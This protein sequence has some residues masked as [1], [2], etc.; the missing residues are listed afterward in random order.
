MEKKKKEGN[1]P[2]YMFISKE[3]VTNDR[4]VDLCLRNRATADEAHNMRY[5]FEWFIKE[6]LKERDPN[7]LREMGT[8][9]FYFLYKLSRKTKEELKEL[10]Y[11]DYNFEEV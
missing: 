11:G 1:P 10:E 2:S 5:E 4:W 6:Q 8:L 3:C 9:L 7:E